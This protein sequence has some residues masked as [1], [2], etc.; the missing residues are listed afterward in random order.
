MCAERLEEHLELRLG[1]FLKLADMVGS[2]GEAKIAVQDGLVEVNGQVETRRGRHLQRQDT[3][4]YRGRTVS[5][6]E[7]LRKSQERQR[8]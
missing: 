4:T 5:V 3:I 8:P 1:Q 2:G 6:D 7:V